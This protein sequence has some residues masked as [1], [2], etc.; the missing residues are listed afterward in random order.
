MAKELEPHGGFQVCYDTP[1]FPVE[2]SVH[3]TSARSSALGM[4][5]AGSSQSMHG[6]AITRAGSGPA[7]VVRN[8]LPKQGLAKSKSLASVPGG[9]RAALGGAAGSL[10]EGDEAEDA[11]PERSGE[12]SERSR[13]R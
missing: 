2:S 9:N 7:V 10:D 11:K 13:V 8:P 6:G 3:G 1:G 12:G 5:R 4:R